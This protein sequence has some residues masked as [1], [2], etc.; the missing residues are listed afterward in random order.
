MATRTSA[1]R[2]S[3][4]GTT[5]T[6]RPHWWSRPVYGTLDVTAGETITDDSLSYDI[7]SQAGRAIRSQ[8]GCSADFE[9]RILIAIGVSQSA[10]D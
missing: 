5:S 4:S 1:S 9:A 10:A 6:L 3:V 2:L 7:F 8:R